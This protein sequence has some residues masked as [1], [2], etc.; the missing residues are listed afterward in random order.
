M[1]IDLGNL[2]VNILKFTDVVFMNY[3]AM[4]CHDDIL[5]FFCQSVTPV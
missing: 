2:E 4:I 3:S 5:V 1:H